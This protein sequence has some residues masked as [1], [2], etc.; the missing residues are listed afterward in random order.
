MGIYFGAEE[1]EEDFQIY[2]KI[3][4]EIEMVEFGHIFLESA[5]T[6][7]SVPEGVKVVLFKGFEE[8]RNDFTGPIEKKAL[9]DF[10][11]DNSIPTLIPLD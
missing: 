6:H 11:I 8:G 5:R 1:S 2:S 4:N 9:S 7:F 3:A 10:I